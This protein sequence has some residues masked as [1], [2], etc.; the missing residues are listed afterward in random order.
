MESRREFT[1]Y[2]KLVNKSYRYKGAVGKLA[3]TPRLIAKMASIY[4]RILDFGS[5]T[6]AIHAHM[7]NSMGFKVDAYEI[8]LNWRHGVHVHKPELG[9]YR[10]VYMSNVL[11]VQP[12]DEKLNE[13][14]KKAKEFL[15]EDGILVANYPRKPRYSGRSVN[16][17]GYILCNN[18]TNVNTTFSKGTPMFAC[19]N[20]YK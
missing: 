12:D 8:G 18:F 11:N 7:L 16:E 13:I 14:V 15:S 9:I 19:W 2:A 3:I 5:G 6:H 17:I 1:E 4:D 20:E 10:W